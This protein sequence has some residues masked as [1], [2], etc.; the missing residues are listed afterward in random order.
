MKF[1]FVCFFIF[2]I[3]LE[4]PNLSQKY[5]YITM[6]EKWGNSEKIPISPNRL[7]AWDS[8][9]DFLKI[10]ENDRDNGRLPGVP[11]SLFFLME[12]KKI[13]WA[14]AIWHH[15]DHPELIEWW[16]HISYGICPA[17]RWKGY[18]KEMLRL[19][20]IEASRVWLQ[21]VCITCDDDNIASAKV[22]EANGWV[23]ER[24]IEK[25]GKK[26]RRY[27]INLS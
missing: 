14:I 26:W 16:S 11:A 13:F 19:W 5:E 20:L 8:F 17:Q 18:A 22:I 2:M 4:F 23:F 15:T 7:F 6:I 12:D 10:I 27:W 1:Y 24:Y 21:R 3:R 25:D 9:E